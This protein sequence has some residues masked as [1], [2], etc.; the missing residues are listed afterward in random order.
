[1]LITTREYLTTLK[2]QVA[3]LTE[4]NKRLEA[5]LLPSSSSAEA[6][7]G[8]TANQRLNITIRPVPESTSEDR[9][10]DLGVSVTTE[11]PMLDII[12][13]ILNFLN[14]PLNAHVTLISME[15]NTRLLHS[16]SFNRFNFRL[17]IIQVD[18]YFC[19]IICEYC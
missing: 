5:N 13:R 1:M 7:G 8:L 19:V 15:A 6:S 17:R 10:I 11:A 18:L 12:T 9:I 16:D 2:E 14:Q 3:E 4:R